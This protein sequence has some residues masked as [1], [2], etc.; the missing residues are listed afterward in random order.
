MARCRASSSSISRAELVGDSA[1]AAGYVPFQKHSTILITGAAGFLVTQLVTALLS[2]ER[3]ANSRLILVDLV[4]PS[5]PQ[6]IPDHFGSVKHAQTSN[7]ALALQADLCDASQVDDFVRT[8]FGVPDTIYCLH[9]IMSIGCE[10]D[11]DLAMKVNID[12]VRLLLDA[13]RKFAA[14]GNTPPKFISTSS[15]A[16]YGG[17]LPDVIMPSTLAAPQGTYG[18]TKLMCELLI[19]EYTRRGFLDGR[20]VRLPTIVIRPGA[21]SAAS[22]SFISGIIREPLRGVPS[23]C[24]IEDSLASTALDSLRIWVASTKTTI[25]KLITAAQIPASSLLPHTR[26]VCLPGFTTSIRE[27]LDAL[28]ESGGENALQLVKLGLLVDEGGIVRR[29]KEDIDASSDQ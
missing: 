8:Q 17:P 29:F 14:T 21:P 27:E 16:V 13:T 18:V 28:Q 19:N 11:F 4:Q 2:T 25:Q 24:P 15:L 12:S 7:T 5:I 3:T 10:D 22:S 23:V 9:G 1:L 26:V 6:T 20:I